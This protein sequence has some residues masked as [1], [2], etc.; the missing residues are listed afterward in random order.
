MSVGD[1][2]LTRRLRW[3]VGY[4]RTGAGCCD[5]PGLPEAP[6]GVSVSLST[7]GCGRW[8]RAACRPRAGSSL[9]AA[10]SVGLTTQVWLGRRLARRGYVVLGTTPSPGAAAGRPVR[11]SLWP[12]CS[13]AQKAL[14][15]VAGLPADEDD[16]F[17]RHP[18]WHEDTLA[19][20]AGAAG[21][22]FAGAVLTDDLVASGARATEGVDRRAGHLRVS[23]GGGRECAAGGAGH[24]VGRRWSAA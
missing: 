18:G 9:R 1:G 23:G 24:R 14:W 20:A 12:R 8:G 4:G 11:P 15:R 19:T 5:R 21:Q 10:A 13:Q 7:A 22:T 17:G 3:S 6:P 16:R 2:V